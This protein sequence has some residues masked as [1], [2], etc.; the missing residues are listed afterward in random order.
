[1]VAPIC[2]AGVLL[3]HKERSCLGGKSV[4]EHVLD[5]LTDF[6]NA[7]QNK[8]KKKFAAIQM[9]AP[10]EET[11]KQLIEVD[12]VVASWFESQQVFTKEELSETLIVLWSD[13]GIN[14]GKYASTHDG[15]IEKMFPFC[16]IIAPRKSTPQSVVDNLRS[17]EDR[18]V[19][20]YDIFATVRSLMFLSKEKNSHSS[21]IPPF[22]H[23][24]ENPP[25]PRPQDSHIMASFQKKIVPHDLTS[26]KEIILSRNN[27][28]NN[29][30]NNKYSEFEDRSCEDANIPVEF[31]S[32]LA[33]EELDLSAQEKNSKKFF[34]YLVKEILI[35]EHKKLISEFQDRCEQVVFDSIVSVF[36]QIWPLDYKP[37]QKDT[38]KR[39]WMKPN[40]D[41]LKVTYKTKSSHNEKEEEKE[42]VFVAVVSISQGLFNTA[43]AGI[44]PT[45]K[46]LNEVSPSEAKTHLA[47]LDVV[48]LDRMDAMKRKCGIVQKVPEQL[49]I[50][51]KDAGEKTN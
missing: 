11:E 9:I 21:S 29:N 4:D 33:W 25:L 20:P 37:K 31:C 47:I 23:D 26:S 13:H 50:C 34:N 22:K 51:K 5:G 1:V 7:P 28:N 6:W 36:G 42:G 43:S 12:D 30:D 2:L 19:T 38:A 15:E 24:P 48:R 44:Q 8:D 3:S 10:H 46:F 17:F 14:F 39:V 35:K 45:T 49:C 32:C 40:R 16:F 18:L 27:K 41:F